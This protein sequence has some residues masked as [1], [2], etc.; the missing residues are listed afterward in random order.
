MK[1]LVWVLFFALFAIG[2]KLQR[3]LDEREEREEEMSDTRDLSPQAFVNEVV[4]L[5]EK[6]ERLEKALNDVWEWVNNSDHPLC[7][8]G[9][10]PHCDCLR[11][12]VKEVVD[13]V[14]ADKP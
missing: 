4:A 7:Q 2:V 13:K 9:H 1:Y 14:L 11:R 3:L 5:R 10:R 12:Q 6:V 8:G